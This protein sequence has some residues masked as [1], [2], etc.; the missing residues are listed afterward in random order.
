MRDFLKITTT[1]YAND[2]DSLAQIYR[3]EESIVDLLEQIKKHNK[4][5]DFFDY[6][7]DD[8]DD[9]W[10]IDELAVFLKD[11]KEQILAD[12]NILT[13]DNP[14]YGLFEIEEELHSGEEDPELLESGDWKLILSKPDYVYSLY[15]KDNLIMTFD[16]LNDTFTHMGGSRLMFWKAKNILGLTEYQEADAD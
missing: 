7:M 5:D 4:E 6:L 13:V 9:S 1:Q 2:A 14:Y 16:L 12:L 10:D 8:A 15:Y 3:R 11:N